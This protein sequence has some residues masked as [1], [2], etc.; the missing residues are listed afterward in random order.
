[1]LL[2]P[3]FLLILSFVVVCVLTANARPS[4][5]ATAN[6]AVTSG[7]VSAEENTFSLQDFGAVGDGVAD[8][9]PALQAALDALAAAGGGTLV[10]PAGRYAI[11]TPVEKDFSGVSNLTI[12]GA[13]PTSDD[14]SGGYGGGLGLSS[15]FFV[16]VGETQTALS[17]IGVRNFLIQDITFIGNPDVMRDCKLTLSLFEIDSAIV[18]HCEFYGLG[19]IVNN[20]A[21]VFAYHSDL[22]VEDSAFLGCATATS[23]YSSVIQNINW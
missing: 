16:R 1:M 12:I 15:E 20:G 22:T 10:V 4:A 19:A 7:R 2:K 18:R 14:G 9:G 6:H 21:I 3:R 13:E 5:A 17:I 23:N 8:D 11:I